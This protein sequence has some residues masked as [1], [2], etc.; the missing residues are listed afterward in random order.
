MED[1]RL[2]NLMKTKSDFVLS[3]LP[4]MTDVIIVDFMTTHEEIDNYYNKHSPYG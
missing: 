4:P 1:F 3:K 2:T